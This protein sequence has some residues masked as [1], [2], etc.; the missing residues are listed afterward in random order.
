MMT[1]LAGHV[2][3]SSEYLARKFFLTNY[4]VIRNSI[5]SRFTLAKSEIKAY[6]W[7]SVGRIIEMK[8]SDKFSLFAKSR[9]DGVIIGDNPDDLPIGNND[10]FRRLDNIEVAK[11]F[12]RS[13]YYISFS[14]TEGNPKTLM[15]AIFAGCVPILSSIPAHIDVINELG[16][17]YIVS[18]IESAHN[19]INNYASN[20]IEKNFLEFINRWSTKNV[21]KKEL[22]VLFK[23]V[24]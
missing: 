14:N 7:I 12:G 9:H 4:S 19:I 1:R 10:Y 24:E 17:G 23:C 21:V 22:E 15:E 5:D 6:R 3:V 16:Y 18:D 2:I 13:M 20:L 8:G 11:Y